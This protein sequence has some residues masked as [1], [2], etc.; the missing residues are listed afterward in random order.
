[1]AVFTDI[2]TQALQSIVQYAAAETLTAA[3][4]SLALKVANQMIGQWATE[5]LTMYTVTRTTWTITANDGSYRVGT[6]LDVAIARPNFINQVNFV[7]TSMDPDLEMPMRMLTDDA[8][9]A[10]SL[11]DLTSTY[12]QYVYWNPINATSG[13]L[14]LWPIPTSSTLLGAIYCPTAITSFTAGTDSVTVPPGY[15]AM[16]VTNLAVKLAPYFEKVASEDL[17][18][19]AREAKATVK[20]SNNRLMDL[21]I[22]SAAL[23]QGNRR[24]NIIDFYTGP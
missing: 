8:Y 17:K 24:W 3:D 1:M 21:S 7:D 18:T 23:I 12:P 5:R 15:E 11:K 20:R 19:E 10:I 4:L 6:G 14:T 16:L 9:A 13:T 2:A 22:E